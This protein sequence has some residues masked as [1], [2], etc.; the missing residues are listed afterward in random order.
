[1]SSSVIGFARIGGNP[2]VLVV[3]GLG[4]FLREGQ[5]FQVWACVMVPLV[6]ESARWATVPGLGL[7]GGGALLRAA[8]AASCLGWMAGA[9]VKSPSSGWQSAL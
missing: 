2:R 9:E 5:L 3:S 1:M 6:R 8:S 7:C 4:G